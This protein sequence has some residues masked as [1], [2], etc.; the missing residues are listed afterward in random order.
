MTPRAFSLWDLEDGM[1]GR[2]LWLAV[3]VLI[4]PVLFE[5]VNAGSPDDIVVVQNYTP[6]ASPTNTRRVSPPA[7]VSRCEMT[8]KLDLQ[9]QTQKHSY[10]GYVYQKASRMVATRN[11]LWSHVISARLTVKNVPKEPATFVFRWYD[12]QGKIIDDAEYTRPDRSEMSHSGHWTLY[13]IVHNLEFKDLPP[14]KY[15]I[16]VEHPPGTPLVENSF[17][18][19]QLEEGPDVVARHK[20]TILFVVFGL[21]LM[22]L[23]VVTI[24]VLQ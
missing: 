3:F 17:N 24:R 4:V 5:S 14:G 20:H 23:G 12:P 16:V 22:C 19:Y 9:S 10:N 15:S 2:W 1:R 21:V 8:A 18:L 11:G 13:P 7:G 6:P